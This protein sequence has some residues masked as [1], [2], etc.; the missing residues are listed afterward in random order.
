MLWRFMPGIGWVLQPVQASPGC[1]VTPEISQGFGF[2]RALYWLC[3]VL[4]TTG[5]LR[6][7]GAALTAAGLTWQ[8]LAGHEV[9]G[10]VLAALLVAGADAAYK[11]LKR[12]ARQRRT[13][14]LTG[15]GVSVHGGA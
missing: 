9:V 6:T 2:R 10:A 7:V 14:R 13:R 5:I 1:V 3:E 8:W 12:A 4:R 11:A 15:S